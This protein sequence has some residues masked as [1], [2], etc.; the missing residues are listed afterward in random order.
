MPLLA[1]RKQG[2]HPDTAF[3]VGFL[4][5]LGCL[6][7]SHP[8][9]ILLIDTAAEAPSLRTGRTLRFERAGIAIPGIGTIAPL[10]VGRL[11]GSE[12]QFFACRTKIDITRSVILK[13]VRAK[14]F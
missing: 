9:H 14:K 7:G 12:V 8:I 6:V 3:A 10:A 13:A 11:P 2:F 1:F 5:G 4:V